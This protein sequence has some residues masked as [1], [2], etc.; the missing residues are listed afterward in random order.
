MKNNAPGHSQ[1]SKLIITKLPETA[2]DLLTTIFNLTLSTGYFPKKIKTAKLI[3]LPKPGK[4]GKNPTDYRPISL[5][6]VP[7][8]ILE[9]MNSRI[10]TYLENNSILSTNQ[11][12]FRRGRGTET[13][14]AITTE[15][16]AQTLA[17]TNQCYLVLRDVSKAFDKVWH[18]GI[19]YKIINLQ[20]PPIITK[21]LCTFLDQ[22]TAYIS[23]K[24]HPGQSIA[25]YSGV[26]QGSSLS[27]QPYSHYIDPHT[28][29]FTRLL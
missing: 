16:I 28:T 4:T 13:A 18:N 12:G 11:P 29:S 10:S 19:K 7:G 5:L 8:K 25:L 26:P 17:N 15:C 6:E 21:I 1:I 22:R 23:I 27:L 20:L 24:N 3:L 14:L 2:L 9:K